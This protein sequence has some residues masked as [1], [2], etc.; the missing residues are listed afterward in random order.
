ML[1]PFLFLISLIIHWLLTFQV[2][3]WILE[4]KENRDFQNLVI[5]IALLMWFVSILIVNKS[6][7]E[8]ITEL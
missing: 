6:I 2:F 3:V 4:N 8:L 7:L 5:L 1:I